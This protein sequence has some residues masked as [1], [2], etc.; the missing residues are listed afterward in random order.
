MSSVSL[1][2]SKAPSADRDVQCFGKLV[3]V[4]P[5]NWSNAKEANLT[6]AFDNCQ[7]GARL[8]EQ[9]NAQSN[10]FII[11]TIAFVTREQARKWPLGTILKSKSNAEAEW[12]IIGFLSFD[13]AGCWVTCHVK[14]LNSLTELVELEMTSPSFD[15]EAARRPSL[16]LKPPM[17]HMDQVAPRAI[18][19]EKLTRAHELELESAS[20]LELLSRFGT[21][22]AIGSSAGLRRLLSP[23]RGS[24]SEMKHETHADGVNWKGPGGLGLP[25]QCELPLKMDPEP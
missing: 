9:R 22:G 10:D 23:L 12:E 3:K 13:S 15:H 21:H 14:A 4:L 18:G 20:C 8:R 7:R 11:A 6:F 25:W 19:W 24:L 5:S 17:T 1:F 2:A 16:K